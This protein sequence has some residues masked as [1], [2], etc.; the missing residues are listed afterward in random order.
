MEAARSSYPY[1]PLTEPHHIRLLVFQPNH[2]YNANLHGSLV[3]T[4]LEQCDEDL[5]D[6]YTALSYVRG[7]A[8]QTATIYL[9]GHAVT[10]TATLGAALRDMRDETRRRQIW[11]DAV[12]IDQ[13]NIPERNVQMTLMVLIYRV[14]HHTIIYLGSESEE[15]K[16]LICF[17]GLGSDVYGYFKSFSIIPEPLVTVRASTT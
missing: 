4:T 6:C 10:T 1:Q 3:H 13:S 9:A 11:A 17:R 7:D 2:D 5:V 12:C 15:T 16:T 14:A 8:T